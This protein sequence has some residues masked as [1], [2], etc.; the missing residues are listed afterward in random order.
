MVF[1]ENIANPNHSG[2]RYGVNLKASKRTLDS[3]AIV[4]KLIVP[5]GV[6]EFAPNGFCSIARAGGN[7][8]GEN[9]IYDFSYY[10][11]FGLLDKDKTEELL[12]RPKR[13][14]EDGLQ[15]YYVEL[16]EINTA[17]KIAIDRYTALSKPLM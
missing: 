14:N 10:Y 6:N 4:T 13:E 12:E 16:L 7:P 1:K 3:K 2:F 8:T 11:N 5:D 15:G 17:L 9:Y